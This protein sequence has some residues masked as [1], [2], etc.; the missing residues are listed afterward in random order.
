MSDAWFSSI[1]QS[2][3]S[4]EKSRD[5]GVN[6]L[7][8]EVEQVRWACAADSSV[9]KSLE[10]EAGQGIHKTYKG[11]NLDFTEH[12]HLIHLYRMRPGKTV[13]MKSV[14]VGVTEWLVCTALTFA[15]VRGMR[16]LY[17]L[18]TNPLKN[19]FVKERVN[20]PIAYSQTYQALV[21]QSKGKSKDVSLKHIGGGAIHFLSSETT[22]DMTSTP[23]DMIIVDER[24]RCDHKNVSLLDDR[25]MESIFGYR[26]DASTPTVGN[27]GVSGLYDN[28]T[29]HRWMTRCERC[30]SG[31]KNDGGWQEVDFFDNVVRPSGKKD[32]SLVLRDRD[33][34]PTCGRD[35]HVRCRWCDSILSREAILDGPGK[36]NQWKYEPLFRGREWEGFHVT[37]FP[38]KTPIMYFWS[39]YLKALQSDILMERFMN[40]VLGLRYTS[41]GAQV[42]EEMIEAC[43]R[44]YRMCAK[45]KR[46]V[47]G[48]DVGKFFHW[49]VGR[50][51]QGD[52]RTV[53][54]LVAAGKAATM[55]ELNAI[56]EV[57]G[58]ECVVADIE[59]E[60]QLVRGWQ[61]KHEAG[62]VYLC[63]YH[64]GAGASR[65][66]R[67]VDLSNYT[68]AVNRTEVMDKVRGAFQHNRIVV[69]QDVDGIDDG[70]FIRH[71]CS[72]VRVYKEES[73]SYRW[74]N[75]K[76]D[77]YFHALG[78]MFEAGE[79]IP[80][81][82][83]AGL[84]FAGE[85]SSDISAPVEGATMSEDKLLNGN[86]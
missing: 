13:V 29:Q 23:G 49:A 65:R 76:P 4:H 2:L 62:K 22:N 21:N 75:E 25:I 10:L 54:I 68:I 11:K 33:W 74:E 9:K 30:G 41:S 81:L 7:P 58:V 66:E 45:A 55:D 77:H 80:S 24:N 34:I 50:T 70:D 84:R 15:G 82:G 69:P 53:V 64:K 17:T 56:M 8:K 78:Y 37:R 51:W 71:L 63:M 5:R 43:R 86:Y 35:I 52:D 59:P 16:V 26:I 36:K 48:V 47:M 1:A 32:D 85:S 3:D 38:T 19:R 83:F 6:V 73:K 28:S 42:T 79:Q 18:P 46:T 61:A 40:S 72:P 27:I 60:T 14:Q 31:G 39:E 12:K 67:L 44:A 57:Y 20:L